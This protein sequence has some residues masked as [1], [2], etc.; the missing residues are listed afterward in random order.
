MWRQQSNLF[1]PLKHFYCCFDP[2]LRCCSLLCPFVFLLK[3][4]FLLYAGIHEEM[5]QLHTAASKIFSTK[6]IWTV[7]LCNEVVGVGKKEFNIC[8]WKISY[9]QIITM[10]TTMDTPWITCSILW[11]KRKSKI[12]FLEQMLNT[13]LLWERLTGAG[14]WFFDRK[15]ETQTL[16]LTSKWRSIFWFQ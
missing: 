14:D 7:S 4:E 2:L 9:L 5:S 13:L 6:H 12:V 16:R 3:Q 1:T 8:F 11:R 10:S 15:L